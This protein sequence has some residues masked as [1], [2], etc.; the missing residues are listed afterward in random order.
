MEEIEGIGQNIRLWVILNQFHWNVNDNDCQA[1]Q[2]VKQTWV[3]NSSDVETT[4]LRRA[5]FN[6]C[7][8]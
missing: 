8:F 4:C 6:F 2:T 7:R 3:M 5:L 1:Q